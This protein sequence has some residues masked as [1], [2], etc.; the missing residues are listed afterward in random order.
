MREQCRP[1]LAPNVGVPQVRMS[2]F[3]CIGPLI[4]SASANWISEQL[5]LRCARYLSA[6]LACAHAWL[7]LE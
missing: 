2:S 6:E 4:A 3:V 7:L 1:C 5:S